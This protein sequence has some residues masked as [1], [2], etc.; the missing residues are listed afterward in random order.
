[1]YN[2]YLVCVALRDPAQSR[3]ASSPSR[4]AISALVRSFPSHR[5]SARSGEV[6]SGLAQ[7]LEILGNVQGQVALWPEGFAR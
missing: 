6:M 5:T 2:L 7:E 4:G 1:M 3:C